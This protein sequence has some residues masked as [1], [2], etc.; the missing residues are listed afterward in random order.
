MFDTLL[1]GFD[2]LVCGVE[3]DAIVCDCGGEFDTLVCIEEF[4]VSVL[5]GNIYEP[6]S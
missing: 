4:D 1:C 5:D 3:C 2:A 6:L